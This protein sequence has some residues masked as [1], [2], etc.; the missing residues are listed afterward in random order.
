MVLSER[1]RTGGGGIKNPRRSGEEINRNMESKIEVAKLK[2]LYRL[3][4]KFNSSYGDS[5]LQDLYRAQ[6]VI[7]ARIISCEAFGSPAY[8]YALYSLTQSIDELFGDIRPLL[9]LF[10]E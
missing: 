10:E 7:E 9:R 6:A 2:N 4:K 5:D 8:A 3:C 1:R